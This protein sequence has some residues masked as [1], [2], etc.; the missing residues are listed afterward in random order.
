MAILEPVF[1]N[2]PGQT[3]QEVERRRKMAQALIDAGLGEKA[4]SSGLELAGRL[5]MTL[6]G[7]YQAGKAERDDASN[8]TAANKALI[9]AVYGGSSP[10]FASQVSGSSPAP[11]SSGPSSY[12]DAIASIESKGSGDYGAIGPTH[13]KMGRALGRYQIMESNIGPWSREALG[14]EVSAEEFMNNPQ[15][16]DAIFDKKFGSYVQKYGPEGAAQAWFAGPGGV[17]KTGR[18]DVLGT[19]VGEY[20]SK[21]VNA[22]GPQQVASA[23]PAA[24]F[25][26]VMPQQQPVAD[27]PMQPPRDV[28]PSP[29]MNMPPMQDQSLPQTLP[30]EFA[31]SPQLA[32][33]RGGIIPALMAGTPATPEQLAQAR[34]RGEAQPQQDNRALIATLLGNPYT[35]EAGQRLLMQEMQRR[36]E[37]NDPLRQ[38]QIQKAQRE[39]NDPDLPDSVQALDLRAQR[40]GLQPGT[41]E[42]NRFMMSGGDKGITINNEGSIPAGYQAMRD[43]EGRITSIQPIPGSPAALEMEQALKAKQTQ[44]ERKETATD[45]ITSAA[46][47][48]RNLIEKGSW[49]TGT[50]GRI[51]S[52]LP[53]S[54]A[55]ELRRQIEVLKSNATIENLT[56]MRQAS[57][58]GGALGNVTEKEGAMLSAAAGA[59]DPNAGKEQLAKALDN[60]ERTLLR[61]IHGP[62][63]GDAIFEQTRQ[64]EGPPAGVAPEDWEFM[65]PEERRLFQQ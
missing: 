11:S 49:V 39:L 54:D 55:A 46:S 2:K 31:V 19:T 44:G 33:A 57:P 27:Q 64:P 61:V 15:I 18:K 5:A 62:K 35:A 40:A 26:A 51:A 10:S 13:Q 23:D 36:Q 48:A 30:P 58:T 4:P 42:Y 45:V 3:P 34:A 56:A 16:Q 41:P 50:P 25:N 29:G 53:E 59:I 14:R 22:L 28:G 63:V 43:P 60:Y 17:G 52:N 24:A 8:R 37:A 65:T 47:Q 12:R 6:M 32:N 21:F 7:Q 9:D 1:A 20:G 38:L